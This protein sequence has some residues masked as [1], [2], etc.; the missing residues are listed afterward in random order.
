ME[1][2]MKYKIHTFKTATTTAHAVAKILLEASRAKQQKLQ[3]LNV[4][5]SGGATPKRLF[6][7]LTEDEFRHAMPWDFVRFF[8][9]DERCVDP[10]DPESN[11]GMTHH[12]LLQYIPIPAHNIFRMKGEN[13]PAREADRYADL[14]GKELTERNGFPVFDIIL[15]GIGDDGHTASIFPDNM[16]LL[17]SEKSV[18]VAIHP[19]SGQKRITLTGKTIMNAEQVIFL[20]TGKSKSGIIRHIIGKTPE[21]L[22]YP[23][24]YAGNYKGEAF[25]YLD[26]DAASEI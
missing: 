17:N 8:W 18:A 23:A 7:L 25:L 1:P 14:L 26:D 19:T 12:A 22:E 9:V 11:F 10:A 21:A 6:D 4:A 24:S 16:D 3:I 15:L 2:S 13:D 20:V 5:V